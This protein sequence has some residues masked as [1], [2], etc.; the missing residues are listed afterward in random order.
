MG[1]AVVHILAVV[2]LSP[3]LYYLSRR[4]IP[5][6]SRFASSIPLDCQGCGQALPKLLTRGKLRTTLP[7]GWRCLACGR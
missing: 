6:G 4:W 3:L 2:L 7:Y 1:M 5:E